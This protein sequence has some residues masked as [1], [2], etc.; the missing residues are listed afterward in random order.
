MNHV[1][2]PSKEGRYVL[3]NGSA[4]ET[5]GDSEVLL[6]HL[7]QLDPGELLGLM[8][9]T[10]QAVFVRAQ[11]LG[12]SVKR[13]PWHR[14]EQVIGNSVAGASEAERAAQL[15]A[16][17]QQDPDAFYLAHEPDE[18][19][20]LIRE[21][22]RVRLAIQE[23]YRKPA[24][25]QYQA[26]YRELAPLLPEEGRLVRIR[27]TFADSAMIAGAKQDEQAL[28][29]QIKHLVAGL[30]IWEALHPAKDGVLPRVLGLG[31]SLGGSLIGEI[32]DIRRFE[33]PENLRAYARFHVNGEGGFPRRRRGEVANWNK[34][35]NRAVWLWS[36][37]QVARYDHIWRQLYLWHKAHELRQHPEAERRPKADGNGTAA[38]YTL[39]HLDKRA[40]RRVG[41]KL[42]EYVFDLWWAIARGEDPEAWYRRSA[43]PEQFARAEDELAAGLLAELQGA[44]AA[45]RGNAAG[46]EEPSGG[47]EE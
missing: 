25:L 16:A 31:P 35:L 7:G 43:W 41:S 27:T 42:L 33:R 11:Q 23:T 9:G 4:P 18:R 29:A 12:W 19:I 38:Y 47:P 24:Q 40:K 45:R 39:G 2:V 13:I 22:T 21:L 32:G 17:W 1:L 28:E 5:F 20:Y 6:E 46:G 14:L 30:S 3:Q 34:Y 8:G 10:G 15:A 44:I 37:D 36:S 26:V